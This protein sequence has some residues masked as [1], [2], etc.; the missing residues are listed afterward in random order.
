MSAALYAVAAI[1]VA[2]ITSAIAILIGFFIHAGGP[3]ESSE[4]HRNRE[5]DGQHIP[6]EKE[7]A[8]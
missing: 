7:G 3:D 5:R 4:D 8:Q 2:V 1:L 6:V